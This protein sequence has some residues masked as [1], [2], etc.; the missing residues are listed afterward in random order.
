[1]VS[2]TIPPY[3][4]NG[5]SY[6]VVSSRVVGLT[7]LSTVNCADLKRKGVIGVSV[8]VAIMGPDVVVVIWE[9]ARKLVMVRV[10][11]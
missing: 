8:R 1:M 2:G 7:G 4:P 9:D 6:A 3:F 10:R 11:V 5:A